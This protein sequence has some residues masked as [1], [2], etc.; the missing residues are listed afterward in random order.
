MVDTRASASKVCPGMD[1]GSSITHS[2]CQSFGVVSDLMLHYNVCFQ[3]E[4]K[5]PDVL[6]E[7]AYLKS[8]ESMGSAEVGRSFHEVPS[9]HKH[10][11][12]NLPMDDFQ[13][14]CLT[15]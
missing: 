7:L 5:S 13:S 12:Y 4:D 1:E 3:P 8:Y 10:P 9:P 14:D 15:S 11:E 2:S 6:V